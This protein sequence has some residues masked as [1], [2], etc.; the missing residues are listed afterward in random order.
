M[1]YD[2]YDHLKVYLNYT[3]ELMM[4]LQM[5]STSDQCLITIGAL[6]PEF[7]WLTTRRSVMGSWLGGDT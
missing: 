2:L 3:E 7:R 1:N 5:S 6:A 4:K